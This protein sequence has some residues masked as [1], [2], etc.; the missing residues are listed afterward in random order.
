MLKIDKQALAAYITFRNAKIKRTI[1]FGE[2][3]FLDL[4]AN[5]NPVGVEISDITRPQEIGVFHKIASK[6]KIPEL[7]RFHPEALKKVFA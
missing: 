6:Y 3:V 1:E 7:N 5:G 4:D 2:E